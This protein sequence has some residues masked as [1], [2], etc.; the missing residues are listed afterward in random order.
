[1]VAFN[2]RIRIILFWGGGGGGGG[3]DSRKKKF[4]GNQD[5]TISDCSCSCLLTGVFTSSS[6]DCGCVVFGVSTKAATLV[7]HYKHIMLAI[8]YTILSSHHLHHI[9]RQKEA[10]SPSVERCYLRAILTTYKERLVHSTSH[11]MDS[12]CSMITH[13]FH[14]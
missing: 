12:S 3:W 11:H 13:T 5:G 14:S 4:Y 7:Y 9:Y 8:R 6:C 10:C 1:M 2:E